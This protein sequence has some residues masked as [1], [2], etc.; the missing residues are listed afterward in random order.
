MSK[1]KQICGDETH[2]ACKSR[3]VK[4][5]NKW[6]ADI[7]CTLLQ[8]TMQCRC[9]WQ[10]PGYVFFRRRSFRLRESLQVPSIFFR[11]S[12]KP[13][14]FLGRRQNEDL[15]WLLLPDLIPL[16]ASVVAKASRVRNGRSKKEVK[17]KGNKSSST[18]FRNRSQRLGKFPAWEPCTHES[19]PTILCPTHQEGCRLILR[20][21]RRHGIHSSQWTAWPKYQ[22]LIYC[23]YMRKEDQFSKK[24]CW[25][26]LA[27]SQVFR[28]LTTWKYCKGLG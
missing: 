7:D 11:I 15:F 13:R 17:L 9:C 18:T 22:S 5:G 16:R 6:M 20:L 27:V 10:P 25:S 26:I 8:C 2:S 14:T 1:S 12:R 4:R 3:A 28:Q 24:N 21:K 23:N 19:W